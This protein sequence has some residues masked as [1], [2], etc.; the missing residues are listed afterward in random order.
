MGNFLI[1][2]EECCNDD[3][4]KPIYFKYI[5]HILN[6]MLDSLLNKIKKNYDT[7]TL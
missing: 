3:K 2:Q 5:D 7:T 1:F 6:S 4:E